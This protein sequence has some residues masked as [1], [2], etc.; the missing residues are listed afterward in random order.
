MI[1]E[2]PNRPGMVKI[3]GRWVSGRFLIAMT[4]AGV[5][6]S[7]LVEALSSMALDRDERAQGDE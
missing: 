6:L 7:M 5:P 3:G 1:T 4:D 2:D